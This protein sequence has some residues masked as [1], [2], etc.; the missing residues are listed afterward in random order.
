MSVWEDFYKHSAECPWIQEHGI[1][2]LVKSPKAWE[3]ALEKCPVV[4]ELGAEKAAKY[5]LQTGRSKKIFDFLFPST[6]AINS[7]VS[8]SE[9]K[10]LIVACNGVHL[11]AAKLFSCSC[12]SQY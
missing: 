9:R 2:G 10:V 6:P 1:E 3:A 11:R 7:L 4:Q 12:P 8:I 5:E